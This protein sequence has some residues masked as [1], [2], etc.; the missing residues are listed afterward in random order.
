MPSMVGSE[1]RVTALVL[2]NEIILVTR[3]LP[4]EA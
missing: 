2:D 4:A 1:K 3:T